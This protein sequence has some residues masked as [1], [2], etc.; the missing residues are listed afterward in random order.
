MT[1]LSNRQFLAT[2]LTMSLSL[3]L[4]ESRGADAKPA[5]SPAAALKEVL[6]DYEKYLTTIDPISAGQR[7]DLVALARWPD[8]RPEAVAENQRILTVLRAQLVALADAK[9]TDEETLNRD[10]LR[11]RLEL[12]LAGFEFD[13]ERIPF[14]TGDGFF[15]VPVYAADGVVLRSEPAARLARSTACWLIDRTS[16]ALS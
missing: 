4:P 5:P 10:L 13:E 3:T 8:N 14:N 1:S 2:I 9:L 16:S 11:E 12:E 7:G 6:K 15:T